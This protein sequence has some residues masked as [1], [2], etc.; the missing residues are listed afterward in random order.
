MKWI[1]VFKRLSLWHNG[2]L[3]AFC[4][5]GPWINPR[6]D[7]IVVYGKYYKLFFISNNKGLRTQDSGSLASLASKINQYFMF[8]CVY[9]TVCRY[10][11]KRRNSQW[12]ILSGE[13]K[14]TFEIW[15]SISCLVFIQILSDKVHNEVFLFVYIYLSVTKPQGLW[16]LPSPLSFLDIK[17]TIFGW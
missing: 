2:T 8:M 14:N 7:L 17:W 10:K 11:K 9:M 6:W 1:E 5:R 13:S 4:S 16:N 15:A 3:F 12:V